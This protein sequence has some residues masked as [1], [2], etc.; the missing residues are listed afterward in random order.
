MGLFLK[1][2]KEIFE[3]KKGK[4]LWYQKYIEMPMVVRPSK[5]ALFSLYWSREKID[6][7][8]MRVWQR[9]SPRDTVRPCQGTCCQDFGQEGVGF[10][11]FGV[12]IEH[13]GRLLKFI[14][15]EKMKKNLEKFIL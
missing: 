3:K 2:F 6:L 15:G 7:F 8:S 11:E 13:I 14:F 12:Q 10:E 4:I 5:V 1:K 9:M